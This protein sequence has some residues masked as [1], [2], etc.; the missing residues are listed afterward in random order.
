M[1]SHRS[2]DNTGD[3]FHGEKSVKHYGKHEARIKKRPPPSPCGNKMPKA[4]SSHTQGG[5]RQLLKNFVACRRCSEGSDQYMTCSAILYHGF[6]T[7]VVRNSD[8]N[9]TKRRCV[10]SLVNIGDTWRFSAAEVAP[11]A[12]AQNPRRTDGGL[13]DALTL[14][15]EENRSGYPLLSPSGGITPSCCRCAEHQTGSGYSSCSVPL[16]NT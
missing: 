10:T 7:E 13:Y 2:V 8:S 14:H 4:R 5:L 1:P 6:A 11:D 3:L 16:F 12:L 9:C 15:G